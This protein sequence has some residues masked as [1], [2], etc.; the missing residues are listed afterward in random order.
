MRNSLISSVSALLLAI[1]T[2]GGCPAEEELS[3]DQQKALAELVESL[4]ALQATPDSLDR[5]S[6]LAQAPMKSE[7][8]WSEE[9]IE[10]FESRI[11]PVLLDTCFKCHGGEKTNNGL[12]VD[13]RE[14]ILKGGESGHAAFEGDPDKSLLVRAIRYPEE[15]LKMPPDEKLAP[16]VVADF[17]RWVRDGLPWPKPTEGDVDK[18]FLSK[19]HWS[20]QPMKDSEPPA[21]PEGWSDHPIDRFVKQK[22][23]E[24]G[25]TPNGLASKRA[26][27]RRLYFDLI[28]LPPTPEEVESFVSDESPEA[29]PNLVEELLAS[30]RY[31]ERW[32]R[33]WM[34]VARY[35]DTAGDGGDYPVPELRFYR[36]YIIDSFNEDKPYNRFVQEQIAGDLLAK[37]APRE[38]YAEN[39]VA[40]GFL[41]LS[42][43]LGTQPYQH[44]EQ[45][46]E[47]SI[48]T[49][50]RAF[51][52]LTL[53]CARCHDHKY[54]PVTKEDYYALYGIFQSTQYPYAGSETVR[55][56]NDI[57]MHFVPL[58]PPDE[59]EPFLRP[60]EEK[61]DQLESV[62]TYIEK[63]GP[64]AKEVQKLDTQLASLSKVIPASS[65]NPEQDIQ[66]LKDLLTRLDR[67]REA[68][69]KAIT[70][71]AAE[72]SS[73]LQDYAFYGVPKEVTGAY[74]VSEGNAADAKIHLRGNPGELGDPVQRGAPKFLPSGGPF[75][76]PEGSSGRLQL[77]EWLTRPDHPLTARVMVNRIWRNH[78]GKG[79]AP[80]TSNFGLRGDTPTHPELLDWLALRFVEKGWSVKEMHRLIV[81]SKTYRLASDYDP[82]KAEKDAANNLYWRCDRRRLDAE[83]VRDTMLAVSGKLDLARPGRHPFPDL[84]QRNWTQHDPFQD[85][86]PSNHRSV[87]LM[88]QRLQRHPYLALFDGPDTNTSTGER[89]EATVPL[90]GLYFFNNEFVTENARRFAERILA[91]TGEPTDKVELAHELALGREPAPEEIDKAV[92]YVERFEE[93]LANADIASETA[94]LEA[95]TSLARV[96]F[97]ANEF[98]Y[99]D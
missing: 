54:D 38:E 34:D 60:F 93:E 10:H 12:R 30:P 94:E 43:R 20:F 7:A 84:M 55:S 58:L 79:L 72:K 77:A 64:E 61:I 33:H 26:L 9:A 4:E 6:E 32:G 37:E 53:K 99:L 25:L 2:P 40:T 42:R 22:L 46:M 47:D 44:W 31:G 88:T 17:E 21:D 63:E 73:E 74:A 27:V 49:V 85:V 3:H 19:R 81:S 45:V 69:K 91:A 87:Y 56:Q 86:Y 15:G 97:S 52:G 23:D 11:R 76:I 24:A 36:D 13:S 68:K 29:Y 98:V 41:A 90:Q 95:W 67:E 5:L 71:E 59:A 48:D 8:A 83:S 66:P 28:G 14:S 82:E 96:L 80:S 16:E 18:D 39:V 92:G 70:D 65:E 78:F 62:I 50:G 1:I 75:E 89:T 57:R 35:A 51:M